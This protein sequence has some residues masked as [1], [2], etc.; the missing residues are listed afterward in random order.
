MTNAGPL[1]A[2]Y[3][4]KKPAGVAAQLPPTCGALDGQPT[5]FGP[6]VQ[7]QLPAQGPDSMHL[8]QSAA[9]LQV[10]PGVVHA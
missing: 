6:C 9:T 3:V 4:Q 5:G 10:A 8:Q 1:A 7:A 2:Q